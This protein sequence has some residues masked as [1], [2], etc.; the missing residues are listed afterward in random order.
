MIPFQILD[1]TVPEELHLWHELLQ[2]WPGREV[3]AD[4]NYVRLFARDVDRVLC[5][6]SSTAQG[7]ILYPFILR[8]VGS[9]PWASCDETT[10][11]ITTPYGYG[12]P[13]AWSVDAKYAEEFWN[14]FDAWARDNSV[15][16]SFARL[17]LF[18]DERLQFRGEE[19]DCISNVVRSLTLTSADVWKD[20]AHKVRKNVNK[21]RR[22]GL[23]VR[24]DSSGE[25][26]DAFRDIYSATMQRRGAAAGYHFPR[27]FVETLVNG[28]QGQYVFCHVLSAGRVVSTELVLVSATRLYSFLGGTAEEAFE[29]RPNDLLK[30]AVIEWGIQNGKTAYVLGGGQEEGDGI[31][32][33]KL[34]FAPS[35]VVPFKVGRRVYDPAASERLLQQRLRWE[36]RAGAPWSPNARFFP[37]YRA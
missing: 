23:D 30:H 37:V 15:V 26:L 32:R 24:F 17:S 34:S 16:T 20:Y 6:A 2:S 27:T 25:L 21:A 5:A 9:E 33:Y 36:E 11:D 7:G 31:F 13:F 4:P 29:S 35:G 10:W 1:A 12:G 14:Q 3:M 18:T 28:L 8:P 22:S 19:E